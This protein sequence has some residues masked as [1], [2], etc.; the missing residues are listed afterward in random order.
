MG[1]VRMLPPQLALSEGKSANHLFN[2][3]L[4]FLCRAAKQ[5]KKETH[6]GKEV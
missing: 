4:V 3:V 6:I 5:V 2:I 1:G